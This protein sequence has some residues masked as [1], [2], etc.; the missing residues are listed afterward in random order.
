M[1]LVD[2]ALYVANT[3]AVVRFPYTPDTMRTTAALGADR[4]SAGGPPQSPLDEEHHRQQG[5]A[6]G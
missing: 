1:T 6:S 5:R 4:G 3:D 2:G